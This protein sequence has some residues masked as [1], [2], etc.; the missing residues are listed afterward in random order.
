MGFSAATSGFGGGYSVQNIRIGVSSSTAN[1]TYYITGK[2]NEPVVYTILYLMSNITNNNPVNGTLRALENSSVG[3]LFRINASIDDENGASDIASTNISISTGACVYVSNSTSGNTFYVNYTC[4]SNSPTLANFTV[5]F[6]DYGGLYNETNST[7]NTFPDHAG[8]LTVPY[9]TPNPAYTNINLTC[10]N[11]NWSDIDSDSENVSARAWRWFRNGTL[12]AG[13]YS[14]TLANSTFNE[15]DNI[16]C[17]EFAQANTWWT[18]NDTQNSTGVIIQV[19]PN[20]TVNVAIKQPLGGSYSTSGIPYRTE[21]QCFVYFEAQANDT[22]T[23]IAQRNWTFAL[24]DFYNNTIVKALT[25]NF[26]NATIMGFNFT[27]LTSLALYKIN[28]TATVISG[29]GM[30]SNDSTTEAWEL[31]GTSFCTE[32]GGLPTIGGEAMILLVGLIAICA[33]WYFRLVEF[34]WFVFILLLYLLGVGAVGIT[35][36]TANSSEQLL[37]YT[38]FFMDGFAFLGYVAWHS[39]QFFQYHWKIFSTKR[40]GY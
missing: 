16:T 23:G 25:A 38:L 34:H 27:N 32:N 2:I 13:N 10:N 9:I 33:I 12:I 8:N 14:Q 37:F 22:A 20:L 21:K 3:H 15:T 28:G 6:T 31:L 7:N 36:T 26:T 24:Y 30:A 11:G 40:K 35:T 29:V 1:G 5:G 18:S 19:P 39:W 4:I 17:E